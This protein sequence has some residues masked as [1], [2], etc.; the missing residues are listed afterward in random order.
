M[1]WHAGMY[2]RNPVTIHL[3]FNVAMGHLQHNSTLAV[4]NEERSGQL[5][6]DKWVGESW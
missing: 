1:Q 6:R 5:M 2:Q 3:S 4:I